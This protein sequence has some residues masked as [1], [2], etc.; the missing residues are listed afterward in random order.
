MFS[1]SNSDEIVDFYFKN[2]N[3]INENAINE[4]QNEN[5]NEKNIEIEIKDFNDYET[6]YNKF[7]N[8]NEEEIDSIIDEILIDYSKENFIKRSKREN[9]KNN[10]NNITKEENI[11]NETLNSSNNNNNNNEISNDKNY[12]EID[13]NLIPT[14]KNNL[15]FIDY[16]EYE[17]KN[18]IPT[19]KEKNN[20]LS[21]YFTKSK[22]NIELLNIESIEKLNSYLK[23]NQKKENEITCILTKGK[24][25]FFGDI[26][27]NVRLFS[28]L[29]STLI[30]YL[31]CPIK[32]LVQLSVNCFDLTSN[33]E[34]I[35]I[36][37]ICGYISIFDIGRE[38][39]LLLINNVHKSYYL[40]QKFELNSILDIKFYDLD[41]NYIYFYVS[42][43]I[44]DVFLDSVKM[45][46][47]KFKLEKY[48]SLGKNSEKIYGKNPE[49]VFL[50]KLMKFPKYVYDQYPLLNK[51][52]KNVIF[53][54]ISN[55]RIFNCK[56]D[57]K[58]ILIIKKPSYLNDDDVCTDVNIGIGK[59]NLN[60]FSFNLEENESDEIELLLITSWGKIIYLY[61]I[62]MD[63]NKFSNYI[64]IGNFIN[65]CSI[66]RIGFLQ[67]SIIFLYDVE[68]NLIA[69]STRNFNVGDIKLNKNNEIEIPK[70]ENAIL[71]KRELNEASIINQ[72]YEINNII[73]ESYN[74]SICISYQNLFL[75]STNEIYKV[76][77]FTW[78]N[79]L[80][81][82][83]KEKKWIEL[84][85]LGAEIYKGNLTSL[86]GIPLEEQERKNK[87]GN[88]LKNIISQYTIFIINKNKFNVNNNEIKNCIEIIIDFCINIENINYLIEIVEP[89]FET[90]KLGENF[91]QYLEPFILNDRFKKYHFDVKII[92]EIIDLYN[93]KN[94]LEN[95]ENLLIHINNDCLE[96]EIII[97][98]CKN[99]NLITTLIYI[100]SNSSQNEFLIPMNILFEKYQKSIELIGFVD[101]KTLLQNKEKSLKEIK[102][103]KQY[104]GH[105]LLWYIRWCLTGRKFP[106]KEL[107]NEEQISILIPKILYW[108]I[109]QK[110]LNEMIK[111]DP[112]NY[113]ILLKNIFTIDNSYEYLIKNSQNNLI[114]ED[115]I[116]MLSNS[117]EIIKS[118][119]PIDLILYI[120]NMCKEYKNND[121]NLYL[122]EFILKSSKLTSIP[123]EIL[124][125]SILFILKNYEYLNSN[126]LNLEEINLISNDIIYALFVNNSSF[127]DEYYFKILNICENCFFYDVK[128]F[129][130]QRNHKYSNCLELLLSK[131]VNSINK[132][133]QIFNWLKKL[134]KSLKMEKNEENFYEL[135]KVILKNVHKLAENSIEELINLS[136]EYLQK[137]KK[138]ILINLD[139]YPNLL[140][141]YVEKCIENIK[142]KLKENKNY[143]NFNYNEDNYDEIDE[144]EYI[145]FLF[146]THIKILCRLKKYNEIL[147][148]LQESNIYPF[149]E[150]LQIC[151]EYKA[152]DSAIFIYEKIGEYSEALNLLIENLNKE[153]EA[154]L[155]K[156]QNENQNELNNLIKIDKNNFNE[157]INK[158][159]KICLMN[160]N[161]QEQLW[162]KLLENLY[163]FDM[164]FKELKKKDKKIEKLEYFN[165]IDNMILD[166]IK[167]LLEQMYNFVSIKNIMKVVFEQYKNAEFK[168][169]KDIILK[170][171][172]TYGSQLNIFQ[173]TKEL[174]IN[175]ILF[176]EDKFIKINL[177]GKYF[178]IDVCD[179]CKQTLIN[180]NIK[181]KKNK[182][183]EKLFFF[184]CGHILHEKCVLKISN[185][186]DLE[187][188][189][190]V[191]RKN[192]IE[193][194]IS[195][196]IGKSL[197]KKNIN[198]I[199]DYNNINE[200]EEEEINEKNLDKDSNKGKIFRKLREINNKINDNRNLFLENIV[201]VKMYEI[202]KK[203]D[204]YKK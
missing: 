119:K 26:Y 117:K 147:K 81:L 82:L 32:E 71:E 63:N 96:N 94:K 28:I 25:L 158:C 199:N 69:L 12:E 30:K 5:N 2:Y 43:K 122:N 132:P 1:Y 39:C 120:I 54:S 29:D 185:Y 167:I 198:N 203:M 176:N 41:K 67:E 18:K 156:I 144:E 78:E 90:Q 192:E 137:E 73:F 196:N 154:I 79:C 161:N 177:S 134:I 60:N 62:E 160:N 116:K 136:N 202:R 190:K 53:V 15:D 101:Y 52:E 164:S 165:E 107:I 135:K 146:I 35:I 188:V 17:Q 59:V 113:F 11:Q 44:G 21:N 194:G 68:K 95:L 115:T 76:I 89:M 57:E 8:Y 193:Q 51:I 109:Q 23:I 46:N 65:N 178:K 162:F 129:L 104:Y 98:K 145:S 4:N 155:N 180:Y 110:V 42:D 102:T 36:G 118:I 47:K 123:F 148:N 19:D 58:P 40:N 108:L 13:I 181:S 84:L 201:N 72:K 138:E 166:N 183:I 22:S 124:F 127:T 150:C 6:I 153:F 125:N 83:L 163:K 20:I 169:F 103:S 37:Y 34:F 186:D 149:D 93:K 56:N 106:Y 45:G 66:R 64:L 171:F 92:S 70:K 31:Q 142:K 204:N 175:S 14:F 38:K 10:E 100:Y 24:L 50:I 88:F 130:Y 49:P 86:L 87:I 3:Y 85:S 121:I 61:K 173:C 197:I 126:N 75:K 133:K 114:T 7:Y 55:I 200:E 159:I 157:K 152:Y 80:N 74:Y 174:L 112:K 99:L 151:L 77:L 48:K 140:F 131:K 187:I 91:L 97:N 168:E 182:K 189:C 27:G 195:N 191:C 33:G 16:I 9:I 143:N 128:L 111:F 179:E 141:N 172:N 184:N 139:N 105:K 170:I